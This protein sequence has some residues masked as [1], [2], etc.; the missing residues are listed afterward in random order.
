MRWL[1]TLAAFGAL[2]GCSYDAEKSDL[3]FE[4]TNISQ[5]NLVNHLDVTLTLADGV[6]HVVHPTFGAQS[7][8]TVELS[9]S[10]GGQGGTYTLQVTAL[11]RDQNTFGTATATGPVA[12]AL[13]PN[14]KTVAL[15]GGP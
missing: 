12:E 6:P 10:S 11:D 1:F 9:F 14:K 13:S 8:P 2:S 7:T 5:T 4:I 3:T 15:S